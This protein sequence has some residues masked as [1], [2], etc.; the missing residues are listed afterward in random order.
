MTHSGELDDFT[1]AERTQV[2]FTLNAMS[3]NPKVAVAASKSTPASSPK[4]SE[5]GDK[6]EKKPV[7]AEAK[8][9]A[10]KPIGKNQKEVV[11]ELAALKGKGYPSAVNFD[12]GA[13]KPAPKPKSTAAVASAR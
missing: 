10:A 12:T 6:A 7:V 1:E 9:P 8:K 2:L 5:V 4:G 13:G 3:R 11:I